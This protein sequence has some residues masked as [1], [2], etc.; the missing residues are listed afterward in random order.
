MCVFSAHPVVKRLLDLRGPA[1]EW[2]YEASDYFDRK[3]VGSR[4]IC[5]NKMT[6]ND[7]ILNLDNE[8]RLRRRTIKILILCHDMVANNLHAIKLVWGFQYIPKEWLCASGLIG[9]SRG[10]HINQYNTICD[11]L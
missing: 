11:V 8:M 4:L 7:G 1:A 9:Y 5:E 10:P 6:S 3:D 2:Y